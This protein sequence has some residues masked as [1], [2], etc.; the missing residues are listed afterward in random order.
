MRSVEVQ[1]QECI[2]DMSKFLNQSMPIKLI[3]LSQMTSITDNTNAILVEWDE[4]QY[5]LCEI[6]SQQS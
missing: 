4:F 5:F 3:Q 2:P 1:I 6:Q